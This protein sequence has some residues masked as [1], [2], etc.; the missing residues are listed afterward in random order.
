[1]GILSETVQ[2]LVKES[3]GEDLNLDFSELVNNPIKH[4]TIINSVHHPSNKRLIS[5]NPKLFVPIITPST[6]KIIPHKTF[7]KLSDNA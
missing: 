1:M 4:G 3:T 5:V 2:N 7:L 6:T